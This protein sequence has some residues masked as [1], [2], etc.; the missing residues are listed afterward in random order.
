M[1]DGWT[2]RISLQQKIIVFN[3]DFYAAGADSEMIKNVKTN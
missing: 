2:V 3:A 1:I